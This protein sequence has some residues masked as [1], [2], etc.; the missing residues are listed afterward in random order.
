MKRLLHS[1]IT[2]TTFSISMFFLRVASGIMMMIPH[3]FDKL[4]NFSKYSAKFADPFHIG[5]SLSLSLDIFAEFFCAIL[6]MIGFLTRLSA[7]PLI[8]AMTV[9]LFYAHKGD[10]FG[11]GEKAVLFLIIYITVLIA[12]PGRYSIDSRIGK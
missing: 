3:G 12:G 9:A 10:L 5:S 2:D 4:N 6:V 8:I 1:R 7:I 11:A